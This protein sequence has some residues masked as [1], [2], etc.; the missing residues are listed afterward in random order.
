MGAAEYEVPADPRGWHGWSMGEKLAWIR[1]NARPRP[2]YAE[3]LRLLSLRS[4]ARRQAAAARRRYEA[5][6]REIEAKRGC[7]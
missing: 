3:G 1:G 5:R 4:A 7:V 2:S 6:V